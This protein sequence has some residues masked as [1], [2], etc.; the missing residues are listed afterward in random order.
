MAARKKSRKASRE[1]VIIAI[2]GMQFFSGDEDGEE[3]ETLNRGFLS[4]EKDKLFL[5]FEEVY[6]DTE[7]TTQTEIRVGDGE[8]LLTRTG[9][10]NVEMDFTRGKKSLS[11]YKLPFG[12]ILLGIDTEEVRVAE[13]PDGIDIRADYSM[14]INYQFLTDSSLKIRVTPTVI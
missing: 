11:L 9:F 6:E 14:E 4:R 5:E 10:I 2:R 8:L 1:E 3:I 13:G 7:E 12:E